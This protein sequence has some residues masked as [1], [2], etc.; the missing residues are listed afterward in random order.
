MSG[1]LPQ[2]A[3]IGSL[4]EGWS[5]NLDHGRLGRRLPDRVGLTR[6]VFKNDSGPVLELRIKQRQVGLENQRII[7]HGDWMAPSMIL[8]EKVEPDFRWSPKQPGPVSAAA[9]SPVSSRL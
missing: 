6:Y 5:M 4:I 8:A 7:V 9:P 3:V 2:L 1:G